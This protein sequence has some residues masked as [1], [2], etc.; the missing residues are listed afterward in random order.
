[1][2]SGKTIA[3]VPGTIVGAKYRLETPLARGGMGAVWVARHIQLDVTVA[4]KFMDASCAASATSRARFE[5]EAKAAAGLQ[6]PHIVAVRDYGVEGNIPYLVM[7]LLK[8][9]NLGVRLH[10]ERRLSLV[11][12]SRILGQ[13]ARALRRAHEGGLIHRDLKPANIFL[14]RQDDDDEV[15]KVLDFGIAKDT[16][17]MLT[18]DATGTGEIMGS[19]HYMSP[20]QVRC[21]KDLDPRAD[22]WSLG[23]ITFRA[24]TGTLPFPGEVLGAV[25]AKVLADPIP[26][27]SA[28]VPGLPTS[29]DAFFARVLVRDRAQ[30]FATVKEMADALAAVAESVSARPSEAVSAP[31][32]EAPSAPVSEAPSAPVSEAPRSITFGEAPPLPADEQTKTLLRPVP[33]ASQLSF[34]GADFEPTPGV[35]PAFSSPVTLTGGGATSTVRQP[36]RRPLMIWSGALLAALMLVGAVSLF[37]TLRD[38][39][40]DPSSA[41]EATPI[42]ETSSPS[43][44]P[45]P[46]LLVAPLPS[47]AIEVI[48]APSIAPVDTVAPA[49]TAAPKPSAAPRPTAAPAATPKPAGPKVTPKPKEQHPGIGF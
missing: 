40:A 27:A 19:P 1:M 49:V 17:A 42:I 33:R 13:I 29:I 18:R 12:T 36:R 34:S 28:L 41:A 24:L 5:R 7:E 16:A 47:A 38:R 46:I 43:S 35:A 23:V 32:S 6:N 26:V 48:P 3:Q 39:A 31:V 4:V 45:S 10:R 2:E 30:R 15:V 14:A 37:L 20:E 21:E 9:E 11:A 25:L 22:L 8:G 44:S